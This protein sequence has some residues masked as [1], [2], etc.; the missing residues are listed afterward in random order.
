MAQQLALG[1]VAARCV[2]LAKAAN[3]GVRVETATLAEWR[4]NCLYSDWAS[5][6]WGLSTKFL[7]GPVH[8]Q[9]NPR[10]ILPP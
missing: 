7:L 10:A 2:F 9:L 4:G 1:K 3:R 6:A 8:L 5:A